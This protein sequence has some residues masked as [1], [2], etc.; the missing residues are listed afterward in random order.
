MRFE[1]A[2]VIYLQPYNTL[3]DVMKLTLKVEALNKYGSSI[4]TRSTTKEG[5]IKNSTARSPSGTKTTLKSQV[6][7][8][9]LKPHQELTSKSR[10][11]FKCQGLGHLASECPNR[12]VVALVEEEDV[13]EEVESDHEDYLSMPDYDTSLVAQRSLKIGVVASEEDWLRSNV[14]HT[15]CT[16]KGKVCLVIVDSGSFENCVS[17]K[18]VQK[19][20]LKMIPHP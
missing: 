16:S 11:C 6:K 18:M 1:I 3:Q 15:S 13:E 17:M 4:T 12:R 2:T 20:D 7:S 8:D 5:F 19:L 14:F 10:S 9:V